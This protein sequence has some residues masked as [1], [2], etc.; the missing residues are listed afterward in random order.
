MTLSHIKIHVISI[1]TILNVYYN[2]QKRRYRDMFCLGA[3]PLT[4]LCVHIVC[5]KSR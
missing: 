3:A 1:H 4:S 2:L 5:I